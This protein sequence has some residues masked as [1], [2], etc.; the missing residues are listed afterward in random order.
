VA[1]HGDSS[2]LGAHAQV[3]TQLLYRVNEPMMNPLRQGTS[4]DANE[5]VG[6]VR[7]RAGSSRLTGNLEAA[8]IHDWF[9]GQPND[10]LTRLTVGLDAHVGRGAWMSLKWTKLD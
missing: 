2:F 1:G 6:L 7:L 8:V 3:L 5:L 4:V 9:P 10:T